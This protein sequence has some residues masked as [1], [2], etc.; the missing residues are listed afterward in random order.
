[1]HDFAKQGRWIGLAG[2]AD[3]EK[4]AA[5]FVA[6]VNPLI[7]ALTGFTGYWVNVIFR[8]ATTIDMAFGQLVAQIATAVIANGKATVAEIPPSLIG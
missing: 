6:K 5:E 4:V 1:M 2:K 8:T 7:P 3:F